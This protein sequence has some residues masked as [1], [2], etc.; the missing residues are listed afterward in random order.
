M[1]FW[2]IWESG[3]HLQYKWYE[4]LQGWQAFSHWKCYE[5]SPVYSFHPSLERYL[6]SRLG[7]YFIFR[8][9]RYFTS[10]LEAYTWIT[11][12]T[13][14]NITFFRISKN[15]YDYSGFFES[16]KTLFSSRYW[17]ILK[18]MIG[19][20]LKR[21]RIFIVNRRARLSRT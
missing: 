16:P 20:I 13:T 2:N 10:R 5:N 9:E 12:I 15:V 3:S 6:A 21:P 19:L 4:N 8:L 14:S 18:I 7:L 17:Q 1:S 11:K